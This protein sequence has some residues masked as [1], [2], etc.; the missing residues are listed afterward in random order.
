MLDVSAEEWDALLMRGWRRFGPTYFRPKCVGC[1][2][3]VSLRVPVDG[4]VP[5]RSQVRSLKKCSG[6]RV[7]VGPP[8]VTP[9]RLELYHLWH[10]MREQDRGWP[11]DEVDAEQ[12]YLQFCFPHPCAR[13]LAYYDDR[14]LVGIGIVDETPTAFSS[15]Y[16]FFH[17]DYRRLSLGVASVLFELRLARERGL[18]WL[19]LGYKV[20]G[21]ASLKYKGDY[22][23]H[24]LLLGRPAPDEEP[25]WVAPAEHP[26]GLTPD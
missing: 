17:P 4:F 15:V 23:P 21:C 12:Y 11:G 14:R 20:G 24:Q 6:V 5:S 26:L 16:F 18:Q 13:E 9:Q 2:A 19:Y 22:G 10:A 7:E 25:T 3:C 1:M 8:V